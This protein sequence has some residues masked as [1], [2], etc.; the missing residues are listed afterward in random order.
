MVCEHYI[1]G[2]SPPWG[3][4]SL[5]H[6]AKKKPDALIRHGAGED[7]AESVQLI[8]DVLQMNGTIV[9]KELL[10]HTLHC[11]RVFICILANRVD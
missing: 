5:E 6:V 11:A 7:T 1:H 10:I 4:C 9:G 2:Q 3:I 8:A